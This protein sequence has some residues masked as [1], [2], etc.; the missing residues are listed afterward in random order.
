MNNKHFQIVL[1]PIAIIIFFNGWHIP[2]FN[3]S[4]YA[5]Q[6]QKMTLQ[7]QASQ[8]LRKELINILDMS[9]RWGGKDIHI[10]RITWEQS[11]LKDATGKDHNDFG[12]DKARMTAI[13]ELAWKE[14]GAE[15]KTSLVFA[16]F[17]SVHA[18][19]N[20]IALAFPDVCESP[21]SSNAPV[22]IPYPNVAKSSSTKTESKG[23]KIDVKADSIQSG[24]IVKPVQKLPETI[25]PVPYTRQQEI[26]RYRKA[27]KALLMRKE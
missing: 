3:T 20:G 5:Q 13:D 8:R 4:L 19:N 12:D 9:V 25:T 17:G 18:R 2:V 15:D 1:F 21:S 16:S 10:S 6:P 14:S 7:S 27:M 26:V 23:T 11:G 24:T 22:P